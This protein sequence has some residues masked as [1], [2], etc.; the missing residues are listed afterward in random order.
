MDGTA[1]GETLQV[2]GIDSSNQ[3]LRVIRGE[4]TSGLAAPSSNQTPPLTT[5]PSSLQGFAPM[6]AFS[7]SGGI[8]SA[9]CTEAPDAVL[10]QNPAQNETRLRINGSTVTIGSSVLVEV[11]ADNNQLR[12]TVLD[13][14]A[15]LDDITSVPA[16]Y[17]TLADLDSD[18]AVRQ[19]NAA[20]KIDDD[21]RERYAFVEQIPDN[22]LNY[23]V[24]IP[25]DDEIVKFDAPT[26]PTA[27]PDLDTESTPPTG[28]ATPANG[29][30]N[31]GGDSDSDTSNSA[32]GGTSSGG[33]N[34]S[35]DNDSGDNDSDGDG[36][37]S[38]ED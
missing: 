10:I 32:S 34:D 35:G 22:L 23:P 21:L 26:P 18:E 17:T 19:W 4:R 5:Y 16:G 3:W 37:E 11:D 15:R 8:G 9:D 24:R 36:G 2:D 7:L 30:P 13:G 27:A 1:A 20:Q 14:G 25:S 38:E 12:L 6:Q 28:S 31:N 33:N 29:T